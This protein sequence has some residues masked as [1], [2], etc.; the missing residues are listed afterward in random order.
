M[1]DR[2]EK[3]SRSKRDDHRTEPRNENDRRLKNHKDFGKKDQGRDLRTEI[4]KEDRNNHKE[5]DGKEKTEIKGENDRDSSR[6]SIKREKSGSNSKRNY[7]YEDNRQ[8]KRQRRSSPA[9]L[10]EKKIEWGKRKDDSD[11]EEIDKEKPDYKVSG[12]LDKGKNTIRG[13]EVKYVECPDAA[14]PKLKWR[15]YP[16]KGEK[17]LETITLCSKSHYLIGKE[18]K[19]VEI[20]ITH[21]SISRQHC[22]IQFRN[23]DVK[24]PESSTVMKMNKPYIMDL[25]STNGTQLNGSKIDSLRYIELLEKDVIKFGNSSREYVLLHEGTT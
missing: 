14:L 16:F 23:V 10:D 17:A 1:A 19:I 2:R 7:D 20:H 12:L 15:L 8:N 5:S 24:D 3:E 21:P 18:R 25:G 22:V 6:D 9:S 13:V 4:K 11:S